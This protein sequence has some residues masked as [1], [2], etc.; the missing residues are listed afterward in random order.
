[1]AEWT[2]RLETKIAACRRLECEQRYDEFLRRKKAV[3]SAWRNETDHRGKSHRHLS[4]EQ[5]DEV[6]YRTLA[7]FPP[8]PEE[9]VEELQSFD[10]KPFLHLEDLPESFDLRRDMQWALDNLAQYRQARDAGNVSAWVAIERKAPSSGAVALME[11]AYSKPKAFL[12]K[13]VPR[14]LGKELG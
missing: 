11:W 5:R 9:Q 13:F 1:M 6:F 2:P 4:K 7:E 12:F 3:L 8:L 10:D 14:I